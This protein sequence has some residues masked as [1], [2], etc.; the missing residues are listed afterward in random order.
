MAGIRNQDELDQFEQLMFESRAEERLPE[1]SLDFAHYLALHHHYFQDVYSWAGEVRTI[2]T[3]KGSNWFCYPENIPV[4]AERLFGELASRNYLTELKGKQE[5]AEGAAWFLSEL[6][7]IH[8][9]REG[10]G[11][12]QL[13]F[14]T[15]LARNAGLGINERKLRPAPFLNGMILSFNGEL[16]PLA[17][18]IQR[19]L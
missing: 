6:N 16:E 4:Q 3:G 13:V 2:R 5:F 14:F 11:R 19:L 18:E 8:P 12:I 9:F 15:M 7:A 10:N 1:G 17:E